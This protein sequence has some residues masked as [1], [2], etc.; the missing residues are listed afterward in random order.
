MSFSIV[1][2]A[3]KEWKCCKLAWKGT[4]IFFA[5]CTV[6]CKEE[7]KLFLYFKNCGTCSIAVCSNRY[8]RQKQFTQ[9]YYN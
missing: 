8:A 5:P 2:A 7:K 9:H 1:R 6:L 3:L 4:H